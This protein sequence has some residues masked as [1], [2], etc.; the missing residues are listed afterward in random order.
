MRGETMIKVALT[1]VSTFGRG[2]AERENSL[3]PA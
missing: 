3:R 1:S 2:S